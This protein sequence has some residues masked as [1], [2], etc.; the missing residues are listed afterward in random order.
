MRRFGFKIEFWGFSIPLGIENPQNHGSMQNTSTGCG[1]HLQTILRTFKNDPKSRSVH[2]FREC[3][4]LGAEGSTKMILPARAPPRSDT[5]ISRIRTH[6]SVY[7]LSQSDSTWHAPTH[8]YSAYTPMLVSVMCTASSPLPSAQ[9]S[10]M[11]LH[12]CLISGQT[13]FQKDHHFVP[14]WK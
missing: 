12:T 11:L 9:V 10:L 5:R 6:I 2:N 7:G 3:S 4:D 14:S 8:P 13:G 1:S